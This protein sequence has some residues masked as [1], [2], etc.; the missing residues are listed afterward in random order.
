MNICTGTFVDIV[1][2]GLR[3]RDCGPKNSA[4]VYVRNQK[5]LDT[6]HHRCAQR[7]REASSL[8]EVSNM[9]LVDVRRVLFVPEEPG[10]SSRAYPNI[11]AKVFLALLSWNSKLVIQTEKSFCKG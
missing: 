6:R 4:C 2:V 1:A 10:E 5:G 3:R 7:L 11:F 9:E 8:D